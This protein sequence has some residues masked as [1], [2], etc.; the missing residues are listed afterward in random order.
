MSAGAFQNLDITQ[1][2]RTLNKLHET[3]GCCRG[4]VE[5]KRRGCD[6]VCVLISKAELEA[7]EKALEIFCASA[8]YQSMCDMVTHLVAAVSSAAAKAGGG[9]DDGSGG[10]GAAVNPDAAAASNDPPSDPS[11]SSYNVP[12]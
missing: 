6:E 8:E 2:R 9:C 7:L 11:G 5:V 4:R 12:L 1:F 3:V 10:D